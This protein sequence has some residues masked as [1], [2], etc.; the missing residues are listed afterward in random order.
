M[1]ILKRVR[2]VQQFTSLPPTIQRQQEVDF[3]RSTA[4]VTSP[5]PFIICSLLTHLSWMNV[6]LC[7]LPSIEMFSPLSLNHS[8]H[9]TPPCKLKHTSL[10]VYGKMLLQLRWLLSNSEFKK[11]S[12]QPGLTLSPHS[13]LSANSAPATDRDTWKVKSNRVIRCLKPPVTFHLSP[14]RYLQV[15]PLSLNVTLEAFCDT[16]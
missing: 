6:E 7:Q 5:A 9:K 1:D 2:R 3:C 16:P 8:D 11:A 4:L 13:H 14:P 12:D 15:L 10:P